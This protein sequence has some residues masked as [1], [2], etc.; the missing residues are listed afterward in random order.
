MSE[1][2]AIAGIVDDLC[3][4]LGVDKRRISRIAI[5]PG[6]VVVDCVD[7]TVRTM[8]TN[9]QTFTWSMSA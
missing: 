5:T 9:S 8:V 4:V 6:K 3:H 7:D 1:S 2:K